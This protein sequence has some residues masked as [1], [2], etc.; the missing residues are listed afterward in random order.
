MI[1]S[2]LLSLIALLFVAHTYTSV[3]AANQCV[4]LPVGT[5][6]DESS[7]GWTERAYSPED[8]LIE[9]QTQSAERVVIGARKYYIHEN[10]M[11]LGV[12]SYFGKVGFKGWSC[13]KDRDP[14]TKNTSDHMI[15]IAQSDGS[16]FVEHAQ[17]PDKEEV[18]FG[19]DGYPKSVRITLHGV[20]TVIEK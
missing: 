17:S 14:V 2:V 8:L 4:P 15:A 13:G 1:K 18:V 16:W 12:Y 5:V 3:S 9:V 19:T 10:G 20:E 6:P 11:K 7:Q